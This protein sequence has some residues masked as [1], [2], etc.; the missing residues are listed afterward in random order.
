MGKNTGRQATRPRRKAEGQPPPRL[1]PCRVLAKLRRDEVVSCMKLNLADARVAEIAG[2]AGF[3]CIWPDME[4]V[5]NTIRDVECH[6]RAAKM[7]DMDTMVRVARGSYTDLIRPF[8]LDAAGI[9]VPHIMS[10]A[11]AEEVVR[12]TRFHPMGRR[13][14]DGGNADGAYCRMPLDQYTA[15]SNEQRFVMIQIEDP[16]PL[17]EIDAIAQLPGIDLILFGYGDFSHAVGVPGQTDHPRV[18]EAGR[19]VLETS[20]K[21]GKHVGI[22]GAIERLP[23]LIEAGY[24]FISIG[25]DVVTLANDFSDRMEIFRKATG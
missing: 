7:Y 4:H 6:I 25:A 12:R 10:L 18:Q 14:I 2:L 1:R 15:Q 20:R 16:E 5:P 8:E 23:E 21:H 19:L 9:M 22:V 24:R 3:D 17:D 13:P 11:D